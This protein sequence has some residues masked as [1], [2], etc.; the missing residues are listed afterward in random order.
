[1]ALGFG[2][3]EEKNGRA[4]EESNAFPPGRRYP[5]RLHKSPSVYQS[6]AI[7]QTPVRRKVI[8]RHDKQ[9]LR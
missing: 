8:D 2:A 6:A 3:N 1:M 4:V 5:I 9:N 7:A